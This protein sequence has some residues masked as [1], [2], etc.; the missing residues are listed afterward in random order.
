MCIARAW[1]AIVAKLVAGEGAIVIARPAQ[2]K[3]FLLFFP[4]VLL[5]THTR[6]ARRDGAQSNR[7]P[8]QAL[9]QKFSRSAC[10]TARNL[11]CAMT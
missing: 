7:L 2:E 4:S 1:F 11:P 6:V 5:R 3:P 10:A 9:I 8:K